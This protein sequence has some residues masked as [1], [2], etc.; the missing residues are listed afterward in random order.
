MDW[1][2]AILIALIGG[3]LGGGGVAAIIKAR[4]NAQSTV[5]EAWA[6]YTQTLEKEIAELRVEVKQIPI[7]KASIDALSLEV[8]SVQA[9]NASLRSQV[10][11]LVAW[12]EDTKAWSQLL[13]S[14]VVELGGVPVPFERKKGR[15]GEKKND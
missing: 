12:N 6:K 15:S 9:E 5:G 14:Q 10:L 4:A 1:L 2:Q 11:I 8:G 13:S 3:V 7:L